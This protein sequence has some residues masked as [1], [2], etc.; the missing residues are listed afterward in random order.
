MP[1]Q[2]FDARENFA[3]IEFLSYG[4]GHRMWV[5]GVHYPPDILFDPSRGS[6]EELFAKL[7]QSFY[8]DL[9]LIYWPD[10]DP[11]PK[12]FQNCPVTSIGVISDY[13]LS[14]P[15][16]SG[17]WP[18]FDTLLCDHGGV[19]LFTNISFPDVRAFCQ[20]SFKASSHR[21][22]PDVERDLDIGFAGN[23]NPAVQQ[24][25]MLWIELL[26]EQ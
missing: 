11:L 20:F 8:P 22:Y 25:R 23:L 16:I 12:G 4:P 6:I 14:L 18:S 2:C 9:L 21:L 3:G 13:N 1:L 15:Y 26:H 5:D 7:P 10:Q 24:Q 17:L 19:E